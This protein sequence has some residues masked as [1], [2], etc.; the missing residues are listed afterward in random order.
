M[1][2]EPVK[3]RGRGRPKGTPASAKQK[4]AASEN[5]KKATAAKKKAAEARRLARK[6][7]EKPRWQKL[8]DGDIGVR[9]L[10]DE[11][12]VRGEV[13]N[14]DETW[15]G[16]RYAFK[17]SMINRMNTEYKRRIRRGLDKLGMLAIETIEDILDDDEARAQQMAAA[18][19]V[20]E[21]NIGKVPEVVHVGAETEFDRLSQT[22]F[23]VM[24]GEENVKP[25]EDDDGDAIDV[26]WKEVPA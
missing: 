16:R 3:K 19:M 15:D 24:R 20:I 7:G 23:I 17:P 22:A 26:E 2:D 6:E 11:E 14:N 1:A 4:A 10:T 21:Y 9:D 5:A 25:D 12:L 18:K 8:L 13:M